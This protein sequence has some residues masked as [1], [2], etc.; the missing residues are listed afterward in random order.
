MFHLQG[1]QVTRV[2]QTWDIVAFKHVCLTVYADKFIFLKTACMIFA[3]WNK[4]CFKPSDTL[5]FMCEKIVKFIRGNI[6][7]NNQI[8]EISAL[9]TR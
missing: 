5:S 6:L 9:E 3:L 1:L 4:F 7:N 2:V 8:A